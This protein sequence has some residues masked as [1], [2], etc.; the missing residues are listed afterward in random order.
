[1]NRN[2]TEDYLGAFWALDKARCRLV[3]VEANIFHVKRLK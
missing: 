2:V 1:M 3:D